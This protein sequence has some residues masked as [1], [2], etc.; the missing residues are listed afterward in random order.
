VNAFCAQLCSHEQKCALIDAGMASLDNCQASFQTFYETPGANPWNGS[1]PLELYRA[2]YVSALGSCIA[3]ASCS[4]PLQMSEAR[5]NAALVAGA[6]GGA[7]SIVATPEVTTVCRAFQMSP[8]LAADAG[9]QNC[10]ATFTLFNDQALSAAA[11]C[12][13]GSAPC[14]TVNSCFVAAFTQ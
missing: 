8:C 7:P 12:F 13:S 2:D 6:D 14:T 5:C 3:S 11:A 1:P 10:A 9:A 4:E